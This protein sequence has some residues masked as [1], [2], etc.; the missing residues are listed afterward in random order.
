MLACV[1]FPHTVA[2][3]SGKHLS[4]FA[5]SS[6]AVMIGSRFVDDMID[7]ELMLRLSFLSIGKWLLLSLL[8]LL[9]PSGMPSLFPSSVVLVLSSAAPSS[10]VAV[11]AFSA[12]R[13]AV[14]VILWA[15]RLLLRSLTMPVMFTT[16]ATASSAVA[17]SDAS[18]CLDVSLSLSRSPLVV[19]VG[20][21][22]VAGSRQVC[23]LRLLGLVAI[24]CSVGR[25]NG[26]AFM[27]PFCR[28]V[29]CSSCCCCQRDSLLLLTLHQPKVN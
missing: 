15:T 16:A 3:T 17:S 13:L 18:E 26:G 29:S 12:T 21:L 9:L 2:M 25:C 4:I 7:E 14:P 10:L 8:L 5:L 27:L 22:N 19:R 28:R 11:A 20:S 23:L 1:S 6:V 24:D